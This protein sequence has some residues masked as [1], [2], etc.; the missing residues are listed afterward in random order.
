LNFPLALRRAQTVRALLVAAGL[1][2]GDVAVV[3]HGEAQPFVPTPDGIYE[4]R[5]RRVVITVR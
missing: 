3:S 1:D 2:A 4:P 5:N